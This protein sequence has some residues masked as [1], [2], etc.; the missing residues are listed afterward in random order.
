MSNSLDRAPHLAYW[1][2]ASPDVTEGPTWHALPYHCLDVAA[3]GVTYLQRAPRVRALFTRELGVSEASLVNWFAFWL[4]LHDL[5]KFATTFQGQR[6]DLLLALQGRACKHDYTVR[7]DTLGLRYWDSVLDDVSFS[8]RWFG[9]HSDDLI[10]GVRHWV[11]AVTGHHGQPP[12]EGNEGI[13][14]GFVRPED[15]LAVAA[16]VS[17][18]RALFLAGVDLNEPGF[19]N[20]DLFIE[21]SRQLSWWVAGVA[22]L[23]DW[24]GSNREHFPYEDKRVELSLYWERALRQADRAL[25]EA[26]VLPVPSREPL[27]FRDLFPTIAVP[28]PLQAWAEA[29]PIAAGPQIHLL[30][31]VTGAGKTEAAMMLTH[32]MLAAGVA[33]GFY[34][35]LP[36]MAT[37]NAMYG[38]L[39]HFYAH[40]FEDL[41]SLSLAS[42]QRNLVDAFTAS[43]LKPG[44]VETDQH[45]ADETATARCVAWLAD[46][47]KR[48]LLAPAGVGTIDQALMAVLQCKHQSLRLLGL[49]RK[50]LVV[51]EVHACDAYMLGVLKRLLKAHARAGGSAILLSATLPQLMRQALLDAFAEGRNEHQAPSALS[52][53]YP[54]ATSW[55]SDAPARVIE[56]PI[57][58]RLDVV[59]PVAVRYLSK[60]ESVV[61]R[62]QAE[63]ARGR[64]VCWMRNTVADALDAHAMF[65]GVLPPDQLTLFHARFSLQDRLETEARILAQ[66]GPASSADTRGGRLVIATQVAEQSLDAD[67]DVVVSDLA[68]ID[69]L[70]QR[71]GRLQRHRRDALGNR[72]PQ[73]ASADE[74]GGACL[75]VLGPAWTSQPESDWFKA[76]FP[77]SSK[78]YRHHGQLWLTASLLQ[79]EGFE[80]PTDARRLIEGVFGDEVAYPLAL[81]QLADEVEGAEM[82]EASQAHCN[83]IRFDAGYLWRD[84]QWWGDAVAPT[85]LGEASVNVVLARWQGGQLVPWAGHERL[86]HAWAYSTVRV[87]ARLISDGVV[88][89]D[90]AEK[91]T[92]N[93]AVESLPD[94]GKWSVLLPLRQVDGGWEGEAAV[95]QAKRQVKRR[96]RY[97]ELSGLMLRPPV[98][99]A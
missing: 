83:A 78:V 13:H 97:D 44:L 52:E 11:R 89:D 29:A 94:K 2:K 61:E 60:V 76:A 10:Y 75:W 98:G 42:G 47:N 74:R 92:W 12:R 65:A 35:G 46:H 90:E 23:A 20:V 50:V 54:L 84:E 5:G 73:G 85:R 22:V 4:A 31:D 88:P 9:P 8:E 18:M 67:W 33:D 30:E 32:R 55:F 96:W 91:R 34:V 99:S 1:G 93:T 39:S 79:A 58:T 82:S 41:A 70:I 66:F 43:V 3:V 87:P 45:Q 6:A 17:E 69:R 59:R 49:F 95:Q 62:I 64:C 25:S 27:G 77:K 28:S 16:F 53:A 72:L 15:T 24:I 14:P 63:L 80:M 37:A 57:P 71:A 38:R 21:T 19:E 86:N 48:A 51:D 81:Q 7:H 40:L 68:P 56:S 36:T 26:G